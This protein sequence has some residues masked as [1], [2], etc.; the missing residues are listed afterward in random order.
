M[1]TFAKVKKGIYMEIES[2]IGLFVQLGKDIRRVCGAWDGD[3]EHLPSAWRTVMKKTRDAN[4]WFT[5]E[6]Q[7]TALE[8]LAR[9]LDEDGIRAAVRPYHEKF[10]R[11][12]GKTVAVIMAG[13]IPAVNFLDFM[14]V[15]LAGFPFVGKLSASDPYWLPFLAGEI[16]ELAPGLKPLIRFEEDGIRSHFDAVIATGSNNTSRYFEYYFGRY[17]HVIRKNRTSVA[18]LTGRETADDFRALGNDISTFYG[19]GCRNV[20]KI[21]VPRGYD[22]IP[23]LQTL[24]T[25]THLAENN[26]YVNNYEY[27]RSL[28]LLNGDAFYDNG[29]FLFLEST[30]TGAPVGTVFYEYYDSE[31]G[32]AERLQREEAD[33]QCTAS[34]IAAPLF[35]R[36][37]PLGRTQVPAVTDY[38]DG[39]DIFG[40]LAGLD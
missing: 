23:L 40:F 1:N 26:K 27:H 24:E 13:N 15:V 17:P 39:V 16:T 30:K 22:F 6:S 11:P 4:P 29:V 32:L 19:M 12:S 28:F 2:R 3:M 8:G 5:Y 18:V 25:F 33:I 9:L 36:Q 31:A 14:C 38:P 35:P 7:V 20:S 10:A 21:F 37:V 34:D